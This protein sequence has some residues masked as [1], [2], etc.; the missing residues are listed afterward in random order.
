MILMKTKLSRR[1]ALGLL[2][3]GGLATLAGP[4]LALSPDAAR[5]TIVTAVDEVYG[6]INSGAPEAEMLD[7]FT[8]IFAR[9]ADVDAIA[10]SALGPSARDADAAAFAAYRAA[11]EGYIGRKYGRRF[12]EFIGGR[13]EVGG[14]K[15]LKSFVAVESTAFLQGQSP[16]MVEWHVSDRSGAPRFFNLIIEGVNMLATERAEVVALLAR[17]NG[18]IAGLAADLAAAR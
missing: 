1:A 11:F 13:I 4:A 12:R 9:H 14:A 8:T 5:A 2:A 7:R 15:P 6:V 10:R 16:F 3:G 18:D 17:R